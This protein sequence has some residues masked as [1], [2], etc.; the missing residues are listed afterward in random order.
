MSGTRFTFK[1]NRGISRHG[2]LR[3]T[4]AY[5]VGL[6]SQA[7]AGCTDADF[8]LDPFCGTGTTALVCAMRGISCLTTDLNPFLIWLATVK[9]ASYT[10]EHVAELAK[11]GL[12]AP[13]AIISASGWVPPMQHIERWWDRATIEELA[14]L[15]CSIVTASVAEPVRE[16]LKVAFSRV[17]IETSWA[18]FRHQS[19]SL[20][21]DISLETQRFSR[22]KRACDIHLC[23]DCQSYRGRFGRVEPGRKSTCRSS[24]CEVTRR[25]G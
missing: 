21:H 7:L 14:T 17:V 8:V 1:A 13:A 25:G 11:F 4:P 15:R 19:V 22:S 23:G 20:K 18:S 5:S 24:R 6:V 2:W 3:L 12:G 10:E 9:C 16:L